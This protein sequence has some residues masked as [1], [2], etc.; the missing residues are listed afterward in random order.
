MTGKDLPYSDVEKKLNTNPLAKKINPA[1]YYVVAWS[2]SD[3]NA[4]GHV[5]VLH[6]GQVIHRAEGYPMVMSFKD[7][8]ATLIGAGYDQIPGY[9]PIYYNW[10]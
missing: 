10:K 1:G 3:P 2:N 7:L 9:S 6:G 4:K 5:G 8:N